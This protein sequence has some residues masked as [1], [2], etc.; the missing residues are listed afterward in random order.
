MLQDED[1]LAKIGSDTAENE[2]SKVIFS[3]FDIP[4]VSNSKHDKLRSLFNG[5]VTDGR[6]H[7]AAV[8]LLRLLDALRLGLESLRLWTTHSQRS[9]ATTY[10][11]QRKNIGV[12]QQNPI[13]IV[14]DFW[15]SCVES[16]EKYENI[17]KNEMSIMQRKCEK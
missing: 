9:V 11:R 5:L 1:L 12:D 13:C 10:R 3:Y 15:N 2:P 6:T 17:L 7:H 16:E 8:P 14:T 4:Q